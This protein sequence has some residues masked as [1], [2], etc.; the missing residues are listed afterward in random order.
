MMNNTFCIIH[1]KKLNFRIANLYF[2]IL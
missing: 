1:T 2:L